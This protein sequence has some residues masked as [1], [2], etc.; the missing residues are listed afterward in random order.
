MTYKKV[1]EYVKEQYGF[2]VKNCW[3]AHVKELNG[4]SM[5]NAPNR[6]SPNAR[7]YPCP[8]DKVEVLENAMK[9]FGLI[10]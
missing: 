2:S 6:Q 9:K 8:D 5:N 4:V 1:Q 7:K 3:I 10:S